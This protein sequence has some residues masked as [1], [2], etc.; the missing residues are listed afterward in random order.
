VRVLVTGSA[1]FIGKH[2]VKALRARGDEVLGLDRKAG[3]DLRDPLVALSAVTDFAPDAIV[4]LASTCSTP[5]SVRDPLTT[6]N[7]T[8]LT[9][10][11]TLDAARIG[12]V[13]II[14]VSSV[15]ARDGMTPYGAAKRMVETWA[16]EYADAYDLPVIIDRPGTIYGPGQE[17]SEDS[18]WIA[19]FCKAAKEGHRVTINGSGEQ[20]RDLLHVSDMVR[21]LLFQI[22]HFEDYTRVVWDVGGGPSNAVTVNLMAAWLR[23]QTEHGPSRYGDVGEYIGHNDVPGW[24]PHVE[25]RL[26]ETLRR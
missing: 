23:L 18:G 10:V 22:D 5:G 14:V 7:D 19:W 9:A 26:S 12:Q 3:F 13:P 4:H 15:K 11:N 25:W 20:I 17:G 1:G 24:E 8:V 6:F 2:T 16:N 21:L